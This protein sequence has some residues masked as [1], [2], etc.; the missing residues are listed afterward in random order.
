[1][2]RTKSL[3]KAIERFDKDGIDDEGKKDQQT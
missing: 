1:M 3:L 2:L